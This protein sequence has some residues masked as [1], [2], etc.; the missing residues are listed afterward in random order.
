MQ[1]SLFLCHYLLII[2]LFSIQTTVDLLCPTLYSVCVAWFVISIAELV[3]AQLLNVRA[4]KALEVAKSSHLVSSSGGPR[5]GDFLG[6]WDPLDLA[7]V[8]FCGRSAVSQSRP[9]HTDDAHHQENSL[10]NLEI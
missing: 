10:R 3:L 8:S 9:E 6:R 4:A 1:N 5:A 7:R 2:V